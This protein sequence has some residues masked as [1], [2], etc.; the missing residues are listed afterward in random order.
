V[1][2]EIAAFLEGQ[3]WSVRGITPS[4]I[5]GGDGNREF[6]IAARQRR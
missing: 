1:C 5:A 2:A 3:G 6:L 4:P